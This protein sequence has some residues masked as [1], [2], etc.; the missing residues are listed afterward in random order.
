MSQ[1]RVL[2]GVIYVALGATSYGMLATF[3]KLAYNEGFTTAEVTTSQFIY[4]ILGVLLINFF[5][6][7]KNKEQ[8]VKASKKN[9]YQLML[10]GTSLGMTSVFTI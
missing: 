6:K 1:N 4:G 2:K 7:T 10:A 5:Q 8:V 9:I 3:V